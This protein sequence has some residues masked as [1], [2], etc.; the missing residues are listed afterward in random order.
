M[1]RRLSA[2]LLALMLVGFA[3]AGCGGGDDKADKAS[4]AVATTDKTDTDAAPKKATKAK[5]AKAADAAEEKRKA[6]RDEEL[7][8]KEGKP[9][10]LKPK[11]VRQKFVGDC[12]KAVKRR[13]PNA[14]KQRVAELCDKATPEEGGAD[15]EGGGNGDEAAKTQLELETCLAEVDK[16]GLPEAGKALAKKQCQDAAKAK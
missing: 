9:L 11:Q 16:A 8:R 1:S 2:V 14:N 13:N 10:P 6:K 4:N 3:M 12:E 15:G 5:K 7:L